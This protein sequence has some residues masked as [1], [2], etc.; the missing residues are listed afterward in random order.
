M[1]VGD[2]AEGEESPA[3]DADLV[4]LLRLAGTP[5]F[6][7][8]NFDP[9]SPPGV[10]SGQPLLVAT[11]GY[12]AAETQFTELRAQLLAHRAEHAG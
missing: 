2:A 1:P 6:P 7:L 3:A 11:A 8:G 5:A 10:P 4:T 9:A 12:D